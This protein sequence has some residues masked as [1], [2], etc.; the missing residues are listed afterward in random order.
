MSANLAELRA[1]FDAQLASA[2]TEAALKALHDAFL[3][4]KS[5]SVT[6]ALK[7]LGALAPDLRKAAGAAIN[8][9][10]NEIEAAVAARE[11]ELAATRRPAG[12]VDVTLPGRPLPLGRVH[13]LMQVR[14]QVED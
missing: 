5:G 12:A 6:A 9:L 13:P 1:L 10:K 7:G 4:R 2:S 14:R 8:T 3:G 11:L